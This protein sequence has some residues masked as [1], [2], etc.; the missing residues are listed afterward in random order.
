M[1]VKKAVSCG[2]PAS[3][4]L[5]GQYAECRAQARANLLY[6]WLPRNEVETSESFTRWRTAAQEVCLGTDRVVEWA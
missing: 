4:T 6:P 1:L 3:N 5:T 2:A